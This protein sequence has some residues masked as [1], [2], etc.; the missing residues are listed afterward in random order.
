MLIPSRLHDNSMPGTS[1]NP[2]GS[3]AAAAGSPATV[4]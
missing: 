4:S 3:A 1:V 2:A